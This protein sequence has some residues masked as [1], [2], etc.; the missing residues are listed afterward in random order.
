MLEDQNINLVMNRD[1]M[2]HAEGRVFLDDGETV[3]SLE[4]EEY[5][6]YDFKHNQRSIIK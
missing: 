1:Q 6:Y 2:M 5:L 4:N 3:S